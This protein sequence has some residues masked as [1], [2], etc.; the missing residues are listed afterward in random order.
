MPLQCLSVQRVPQAITLG[1]AFAQIFA[2][3]TAGLGKGEIVL[4][5]AMRQSLKAVANPPNAVVEEYHGPGHQVTFTGTGTYARTAARCELSDLMV[6]AYDRQRQ[7]A[8]LSYI[9]AKSER[10]VTANANGIA[11]TSLSANMEQWH[12]LATRPPIAGVGSFQPPPDLLSSALLASVGSF[13]FFLHGSSAPDIYYAAASAMSMPYP[14]TSRSGKLTAVP[15]CCAC[16]PH[17]ECLSVYGNADFGAFLFGLMIGTPIIV[18]GR[19]VRSA[20]INGW[21][22]AQLRGFAVE[23]TTADRGAELAN[24]IARLLDPDNAPPAQTPNVGAASLMILGIGDANER[25]D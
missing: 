11:T 14:Y 3:N 13:A 23:A 17:P 9:Q 5:R 18:G 7:D 1:R 25:E 20:S 12:L 6:I 2:A 19:T 8:R 16:G 10:T 24:E 15:E 21:L 22:A 4:F